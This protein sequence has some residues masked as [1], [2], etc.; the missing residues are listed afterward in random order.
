ERGG[1]KLIRSPFGT[2]CGC[3]ALRLSHKGGGEQKAD[4][5]I[6]RAGLW[7]FYDLFVPQGEA[8]RGVG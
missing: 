5:L 4:S 1:K 8:M 6:L 7:L 3:S 2:A